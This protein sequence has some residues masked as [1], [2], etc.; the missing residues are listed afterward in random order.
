[1]DFRRASQTVSV[2]V[3]DTYRRFHAFIDILIAR[4]SSPDHLLDMMLV[5]TLDGIKRR[6]TVNL[7]NL[8]VRGGKITDM[9]EGQDGGQ[10]RMIDRTRTSVF[11]EIESLDA[12]DFTPLVYQEMAQLL[13]C[14][15]PVLKLSET[16]Y[17]IGTRVQELDVNEENEVILID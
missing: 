10:D 9:Q 5:N 8:Y 3:K 12:L 15:I 1:M 4:L 13:C 14:F 11:R 17:L 16:H 6:S 7:F 2:S